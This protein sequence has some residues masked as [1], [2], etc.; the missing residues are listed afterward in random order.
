V[1]VADVDFPENRAS[2]AHHHA[3][4]FRTLALRSRTARLDGVWHDTVFLERRSAV[5]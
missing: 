5:I 3:A 4:G 1:D 2:V